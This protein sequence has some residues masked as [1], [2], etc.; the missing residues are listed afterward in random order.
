MKKLNWLLVVLVAAVVGLAGCSK[1]A[2]LAKTQ[3]VNGVDVAFPELMQS[4]IDNK[5]KDVQKALGNLA[6]GLRYGDLSAVQ[7]DLDS[8]ANNATVNDAQKKLVATVSEQVKTAAAQ[9][10]PA[11]GK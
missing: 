10:P 11:P 8:L 3:K 7:K 5:D 9:A 1:T 2:K 4:L 6:F